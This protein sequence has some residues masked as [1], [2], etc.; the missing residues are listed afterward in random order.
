[1]YIKHLMMDNVMTL[2]GFVLV[3]LLPE[4]RYYLSYAKPCSNQQGY[5]KATI[6]LQERFVFNI[7]SIQVS[8]INCD[9][10]SN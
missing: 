5:T 7:V 6:Q 8:L 2:G 10:I 4:L 9:L 3:S 1:M